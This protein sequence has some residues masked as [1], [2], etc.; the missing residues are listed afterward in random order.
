VYRAVAD[1]LARFGG[2]DASAAWDEVWAQAA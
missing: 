1:S 2:A